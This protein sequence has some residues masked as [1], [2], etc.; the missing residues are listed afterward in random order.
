MLSKAAPSLTDPCYEH[1]GGPRTVPRSHTQGQ[2]LQYT[3]TGAVSLM[4]SLIR[5]C[6]LHPPT[7]P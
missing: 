4:G 3:V 6:M 7:A 1:S 2:H 5:A